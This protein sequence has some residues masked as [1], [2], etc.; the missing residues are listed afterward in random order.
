MRYFEDTN[1]LELAGAVG[2]SDESARTWHRGTLDDDS[3]VAAA[4][5]TQRPAFDG[6]LL[7]GDS[8]GGRAVALPLSVAGRR[9]GALGLRYADERE[10]GESDLRRIAFV[11]RRTAQEFD[12]CEREL[13]HD[14]T[15]RLQEVTATL[16]AAHSPAEIVEAILVQGVDALGADAGAVALVDDNRRELKTVSRG[17]PP[18][19]AHLLDPLPLNAAFPLA[20]AARTGEMVVLESP[21]EVDEA[22]PTLLEK[23]GHPAEY[24]SVS[25]PIAA[26]GPPMGAVGFGFRRTRVFDRDERAFLLALSRLCGQALDR[27]NRARLYDRTARLQ[28][29][30]AQLTQ[31]VTPA[32]VA[33][34]VVDEGVAAL[35]ADAARMA[36]FDDGSHMLTTVA[37]GGLTPDHI[38]SLLR[39][40]VDDPMPIAVAASTG[41]PVLI[42]SLDAAHEKWSVAAESFDNMGFRA[43]AA[44]PL[45]GRET[46][47]GAIGFAWVE[48]RRFEEE[49]ESFLGALAGVCAQALERARLFETV[50]RSRDGLRHLLEHIGEGV[51]AVDGRLVIA[52]ANEEAA[53]ILGQDQ[54]TGAQLPD[55]WPELAL[56]DL[57]RSVMRPDAGPRDEKVTLAGGRTFVIVGIPG[58]GLTTLVLRDVSRSERLERAER[59]FAANAAHE[60]R[61]PLT[62]IAAAVDALQRG[63]K[64]HP[65]E[66][67]FYLAGLQGE[68]D[69]LT[70]L[71]QALLLL[72]RA[73]GDPELLRCSRVDVGALVIDVATRLEARPGVRVLVRGDGGA[74]VGD[75][76]L[77]DAALTNVARNASRH[78]SSG[79]ITLSSRTEPDGNVVIEVADTGD[80][81]PPEVRERATERFY[82]GGDRDRDGFG[83]GLPLALQMVEALGGRLE[84]TSRPA[85]GPSCG[86]AFP[87]HE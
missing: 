63:A 41:E 8:T 14:L 77:L 35:R 7:P 65:A 6:G 5:H 37:A 59:E 9:L 31:A 48:D 27:A 87:A 83:L 53:R 81:M 24:A 15:R 61:T 40:R 30:T 11:A 54:L 21:A 19:L 62:A 33:R 44:V 20:E 69:R 17:F 79:T 78:T 72:A 45:L 43:I 12:R 84:I 18:E 2:R 34:A 4:V 13:L 60:L 86:S 57:A 22:Y 10:I 3:L 64:D 68:A 46:I 29:V 75:R 67:D 52:Y 71:S 32:D 23:R 66:R 49:D 36:I 25:L 16:A 85:P 56:R 55:P 26:G 76:A 47:L 70:G 28:A 1:Q 58:G 74:A 51:V 73:Q 38:D 82:R 39:L 80:G 50:E 42:E